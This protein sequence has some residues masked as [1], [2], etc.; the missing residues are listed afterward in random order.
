MDRGQSLY[1]DAR[2]DPTHTTEANRKDQGQ[3]VENTINSLGVLSHLFS[4]SKAG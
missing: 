1:Y 2:E 4:K 3:V